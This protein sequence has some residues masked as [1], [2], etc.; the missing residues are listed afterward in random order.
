MVPH[1]HGIPLWRRRKQLRFRRSG[2]DAQFENSVDLMMQLI[3][4]PSADVQTLHS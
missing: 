3:R 1:G 4:N 2:L